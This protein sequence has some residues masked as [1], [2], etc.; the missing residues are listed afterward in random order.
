M[1]LLVFTVRR[2]LGT[3]AL[4]PVVMLATFALLRGAGGSPFRPP[5]GYF[6]VPGPYQRFL[7]DFYHLDDP[8]VVQYLIYVK[9]VFTFNF[10]PSQVQRSLD[11]TD[12][13]RMSFP[14][15][16]Q[17]VLLA[18][19]WALP[20]GI[21]LGVFAATRRNSLLDALTTSTASVM[22]V[23]PV[24]FVAFL[25]STYFVFEWHLFP[26]GW[27]GWRAKVLPSITL[28]L[29]PTGY[30]ARLVRGAVVEQ[31]QEDYVR[32]A[33]AKGLLWRRIVWTHV[34]RNSLVPFLSAAIPMLAMLI[35]GAFFVE[36]LFRI[37]GASSFFVEAALTRDYP[38]MM[39]MSVALAIVVL[40]AN[41][42]A[43]LALVLLDPRLRE[44]TS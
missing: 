24:F 28:A 8:W 14:V 5:E 32:T 15:T 42:L 16:L 41:F 12:V 21:G 40:F 1:S 33:R 10:G 11:V 4:I 44:A 35:T 2:L 13:I 37:P 34:L 36:Q 6:V 30:I 26:P 25:L 29:A 23:V 7:S 31:L 19:A 39:G 20:L 3:L 17:L 9:N 22:L 27:E 18:V 38:L 43:D